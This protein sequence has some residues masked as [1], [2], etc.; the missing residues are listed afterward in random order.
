[1][2]TCPLVEPHYH[3]NRRSHILEGLCGESRCWPHL[4][5]RCLFEVGLGATVGTLQTGYP[6]VPASRKDKGKDVHPRAAT[7]HAVPNPAMCPTIPDPTSLLERAPMPPHIPWLRTPSPGA[8][9]LPHVP[10]LQTLSLCSEGLL[11][12]HESHGSGP[13]LPARRGS[14]AAMRP[15]ALYRPWIKKC[16]VATGMQ[17]GSRVTE[18]RTHITEATARSVGRR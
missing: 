16:W 3:R 4:Q 6:R 5:V 13:C 17:P 8:S 9:V 11:C 2:D 15:A 1:V 10:S 7:R 14:G 18:V 12:C